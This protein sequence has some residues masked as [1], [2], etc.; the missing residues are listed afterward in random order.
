MARFGL[1]SVALLLLAGFLF[2]GTGC[3]GREPAPPAPEKEARRFPAVEEQWGIR[4]LTLR[5]TGAD[6]FLDF[7]YR[8]LDP[9]KASGMMGRDQKAY[10]IHETSGTR[11]PVPITKLG[12]LKGSSQNPK[13]D[14]VYAV[15]FNNLGKV[16]GGGDPVTIVI[17]K[18][19]LEGMSVEMKP[20]QAPSP[21]AE[22]E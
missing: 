17:G 19:R 5:L 1:L 3:A 16:A 21:S 13:P 18:M 22:A 10:L 15:L 11:L 2:F 4:P 12:P 20:G 6:H 8:I 7:R 9:E 14:R